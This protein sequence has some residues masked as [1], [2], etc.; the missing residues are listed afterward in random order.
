M[1]DLDHM[2]ARCAKHH[3]TCCRASNIV[4]TE[5]DVE[6][7]AAQ[8]GNTDFIEFRPW[9]QVDFDKQAAD[10]IFRDGVYR[11]DGTQRLLKHHS[12]GDCFFLGDA[13]CT[14]SGETRPLYCR[15]YPF[16]YSAEGLLPDAVPGC[17]LHLLPP[18]LDLFA[19]LRMNREEAE[20]WRRQLYAELQSERPLATLP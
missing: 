5:G 9:K 7:I 10:P 3:D 19:A 18:G 15:L 12:N 13:G 4:V 2:C 20:K 6:R 14:L 11:P 17:P 16:D 1:T 8:T